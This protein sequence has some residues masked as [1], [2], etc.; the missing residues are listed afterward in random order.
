M[1]EEI[2]DILVPSGNEEEQFT[3]SRH[4]IANRTMS[5]TLDSPTLARLETHTLPPIGIPDW[6]IREDVPSR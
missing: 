2:I 3:E 6:K 5:E 4:V 1:I